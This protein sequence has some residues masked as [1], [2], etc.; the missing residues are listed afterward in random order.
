MLC[1]VRAG[2]GRVCVF[3]VADAVA[4]TIAVACGA[5][6][7]GTL[8][9]VAVAVAVCV[10]VVVAVAVC[11]V[12]AIAIHLLHAWQWYS[13]LMCTDISCDGVCR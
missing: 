12:V 11:V 13:C 8:A 3:V 9:I 10:V 2:C 6:A 4:G 1:I 7:C 5:V